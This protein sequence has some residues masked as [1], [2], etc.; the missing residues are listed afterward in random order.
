[1]SF[2][3][4]FMDQ[5]NKIQD[6]NLRKELLDQELGV[7]QKEK[8]LDLANK[9]RQRS[10]V[11]DGEVNALRALKQRLGDEEGADEYLATVAKSGM[12]STIMKSINGL[13]LDDPNKELRLR[14][15]SIM[16]N[17]T[18]YTD[19][20]SGRPQMKVPTPQEILGASREELTKMEADLMVAGGATKDTS[21][22][23]IN[24]QGV[25]SANNK[26]RTEAMDQF[27]S[28]LTSRLSQTLDTQDPSQAAELMKDMEDAGSSNAVTASRGLS[29]MMKT[30]E[31]FGVYIEMLSYAGETP[32]FGVVE[33]MPE[34][35][36]YRKAM[37]FYQNWE[38]L[39]P[40]NR[41]R[42]IQEFPF[43]EPWV[44]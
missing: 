32:S 34:F 39:R 2:V 23:D 22:V 19:P 13:E 37:P 5:Y 26:L 24:P 11:A 4:G 28:T 16:D 27:T 41:Q 43:L 20:D 8:V 36:R 25:F 33:N 35:D 18:V 14:G 10:S 42:V 21:Y 40:E 3:A 44:N 17:F 7:K 15:A 12:A 6:R 38:T 1:M 29:S 30:P 31:G 9:Y